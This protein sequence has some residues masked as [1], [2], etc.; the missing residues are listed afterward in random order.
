MMN[1]PVLMDEWLAAGWS[2]SVRQGELKAQ[3][4][5]G[6]EIVLWRSSA[7]IHAWEDLCV[8]RGTRLSLG[9]VRNDYLVCPY[10]F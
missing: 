1:D 2:S 9:Q 10:H 7:G 3:R 8:H 6:R 4:L 5:L